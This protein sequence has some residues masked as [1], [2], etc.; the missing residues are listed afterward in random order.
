VVCSEVGGRKK[1]ISGPKCGT[2]TLTQ[3]G[4]V[5]IRQHEP[6]EEKGVTC[7]AADNVTEPWQASERRRRGETARVGLRRGATALAVVELP[8]LVKMGKRNSGGHGPAFTVKW[9]A[10]RQYDLALFYPP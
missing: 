10:I 3:Y 6:R 2:L 5:T 7:K 9:A 1:R 4:S 8:S